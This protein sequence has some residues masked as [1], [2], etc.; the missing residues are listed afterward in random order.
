MLNEK[1]LKLLKKIGLNYDYSKTL[2]DEEAVKVEEKAGDYLNEYGLDEE[3][4][5]NE[6]GKI[7]QSILNKIDEL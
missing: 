6:I 4:N 7:C 3:Y 2:S 1:E 5:Q